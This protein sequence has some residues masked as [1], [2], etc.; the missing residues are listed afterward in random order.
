MAALLLLAAA[1]AGPAGSSAQSSPSPSPSPSATPNAIGPAF[2]ANDPCTSLSVLVSRPTVTSSVCTVR[3]NHVLI[4]TGYLNTSFEAGGGSVSAPQALIRIGTAI[5]ALELQV[6]PPG[7]MRTR[8]NGGAIAASTDTGAGLKYVFGYTPKFNYGGQAFFTAPTGLNGGS[9]NGT[10]AAYGLNGGFTLSSAFSLA[11]TLTASSQTNGT[12]R[13][14]SFAPSLVLGAALPN[15]TGLYA[16]WAQTSNATGPASATRTQYM[17][18][19]YRDLGQRLQLDAS[20][21][22]SPTAATGTYRAVGVGVSY[23]F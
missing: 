19:L 10:T 11:T 22:L 18:G 13:W 8:G 15:A 5:P 4:E 20:A 16:E 3:P 17:F 9:S 21:A 2:G 14:S 12:Q 6:A 23:Y 7:L 1:L